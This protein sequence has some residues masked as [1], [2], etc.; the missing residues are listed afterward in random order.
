[1]FELKADPNLPHHYIIGVSVYNTA[2]DSVNWGRLYLKYGPV[3]FHHDDIVNM[4][5]AALLS[6]D[7]VYKTSTK[8]AAE[9]FNCKDLAVAITGLKLAA[10]VNQATLHHFS[11]EFKFD[12]P[13][14]WFENFVK[15]A[16][17]SE[18]T[19]EKLNDARIGGY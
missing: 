9:M 14:E 1:M 16:N 18:S 7:K 10:S 3:Y 17:I 2:H 19:K 4:Q 11:S 15:V 8:E 6:V 5:D 12:N 13:D